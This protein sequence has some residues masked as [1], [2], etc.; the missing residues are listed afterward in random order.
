VARDGG[1]TP[2]GLVDN[3]GRLRFSSS[4]NKRSGSL[5]MGSLCFHKPS[6]AVRGGRR[7]HATMMVRVLGL[8]VL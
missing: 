2:P 6:I 4:S 7:W 1:T 3:G 5:A 8:G